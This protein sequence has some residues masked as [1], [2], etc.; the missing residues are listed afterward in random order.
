M[1][2]RFSTTAIAASVAVALVALAGLAVALAVRDDGA[3]EGDPA[4]S[5]PGLASGSERA[6]I[7]D[8]D[9][10]VAPTDRYVM[11]VGAMS[12][13]RVVTL[14][15]ADSVLAGTRL[16]IGD[17]SGTVDE[18]NS[19]VVQRAEHLKAVGLEVV[20]PPKWLTGTSI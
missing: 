3:D 1:P 4:H 9:Y 17:E 14:P 15:A 18:T 13:T 16:T 6:T 8:E 5:A 2:E 20:F 19:L 10:V 12:A 11:Q 7:S